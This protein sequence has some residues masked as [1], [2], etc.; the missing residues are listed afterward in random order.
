[1]P[2]TKSS[3][4]IQTDAS[5]QKITSKKT[6][7][8]KT[9]SKKPVVSKSARSKL[10]DAHDQQQGQEKGS[11]TQSPGQ[12]WL[13]S[14]IDLEHYAPAY[15]TFITTKLVSG[16]ASV[17][18]RHFG[19]GI[20][21]WR[22]LVMLALDEYV[23]VNMVC[24]LIGMDKGSVSRA[25]KTMYELGLVKF[26]SDPNDGRMRYATLTARGRRKHDE[27]KAVALA[28]ERAFLSCLK[29]E[30]VPVL[31]Q[32]LWR[33]HA[34]LP[35]VE[36]ATAQYLQEHVLKKPARSRKMTEQKAV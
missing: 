25:F 19:V 3:R 15:F 27:I 4:T 32:M 18:R 26:S 8:K 23:S 1:M 36:R 9:A 35:E 13:A 10:L 5:T 2:N 21:V 34:N 24:Q 12:K 31:M 11:D 20:E 17:Y 29:P 22:V 33:L 30:E 14:G 6:A 16:A 7:L 28:R